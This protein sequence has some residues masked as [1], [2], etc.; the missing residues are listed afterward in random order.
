[1][2][3]AV[4]SCCREADIRDG[5]GTGAAVLSC[6]RVE[7]VAMPEHMHQLVSEPE[8]ADLA[9][10]IKSLKQ[11]VARPLIGDA[12]HFWQARYYDFTSTSGAGAQTNCGTC[13]AIR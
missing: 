7:Y 6:A 1:M 3:A 10:A 11:G 2:K 8:R 4:E 5:T 12:D 9:T 13:I